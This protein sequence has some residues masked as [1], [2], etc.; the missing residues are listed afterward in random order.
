MGFLQ[1][2]L[3]NIS[4]TGDLQLSEQLIFDKV[5]GFRNIVPGC[6]CS[7]LVQNVAVA[8]TS[9]SRNSVCVLDV[10]MLYPMQFALLS[11]KTITQSKDIFDFDVLAS[12]VAFPTKYSNLYIV[13][14][15]DRTVI[16]MMSSRDS[17]QLISRLIDSLKSFFDIILID[18]SYEM[19]SIVA[20]AAVK[21]NKIINVVDMSLKSMYNLKKSINTMSTMAIPLAKANKVV[22]NKVVPDMLVNSKTALS[23]AGLKVI[24]EVPFSYEIA[25]MGVTGALIHGSSSQDDG[26][27]AFNDVLKVIVDDILQKTPLNTGVVTTN[28]LIKESLNT[29]SQLDYLGD[30]IAETTQDINST[31]DED[32]DDEIEI[33]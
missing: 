27:L 11:D 4:G 24:G 10:N 31:S 29:A 17:E 14:F 2:L 7:T 23:E 19:T 20:H 26:V 16:D 8:L 9:E 12:D 3:K 6:G 15:K 33:I 1:K 21:C 28:M 5:I 13:S 18:L 30:N 25:K 22:L 32:N